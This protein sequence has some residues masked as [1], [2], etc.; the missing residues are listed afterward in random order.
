MPR[1]SRRRLNGEPVVGELRTQ[2]DEAL[3]RF[4]RTEDGVTANRLFGHHGGD[5]GAR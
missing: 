2:P 1:K 4:P 3:A 5:A